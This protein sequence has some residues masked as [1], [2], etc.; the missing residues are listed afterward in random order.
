MIT[1]AL[2]FGHA[3]ERSDDD[4][5]G[6]KYQNLFATGT[7][8]ATTNI[9][10]RSILK[11]LKILNIVITVNISNIFEWFLMMIN[12]FGNAKEGT[13]GGNVIL[14]KCTKKVKRDNKTCDNLAFVRKFVELNLRKVS[15]KLLEAVFRFKRV[16]F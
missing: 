16:C 12:A 4:Y 6:H 9:F 14:G 3:Y 8:Q 7:H 11:I 2:L 10:V 5:K 1:A 13:V 15:I